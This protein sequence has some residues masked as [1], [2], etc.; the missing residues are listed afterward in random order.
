MTNTEKVRLVQ[1][2]KMGWWEMCGVQR[3]LGKTNTEK[4]RTNMEKVRLVQKDWIKALVAERLTSKTYFGVCIS[5]LTQFLKFFN[6]QTKVSSFKILLEGVKKNNN[7]KAMP[8]GELF[9]K[10]KTWR[11]GIRWL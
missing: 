4:V 10:T 7:E 8:W 2:D 6:Q 9:T 5:I 1:E 3:L 11:I